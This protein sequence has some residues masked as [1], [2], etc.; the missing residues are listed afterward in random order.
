MA[1]QTA[2]WQGGTAFASVGSSTPHRLTLLD[3][4]TGERLAPA[5]LCDAD[6][7]TF[8]LVAGPASLIG[9]G[10]RD[11][12]EPLDGTRHAHPE[13]SSSGVGLLTTVTGSPEPRIV[14]AHPY[15]GVKVWDAAA[16]RCL[17]ELPLPELR[18]PDCLCAGLLS[19]TAG[20]VDTAHLVDA[21]T[22]IAVSEDGQVSV[23]EAE[24]GRPV[25]RWSASGTRVT[26]MIWARSAIGG[27]DALLTTDTEARLCAWDPRTGEPLGQARSLP[28]RPLHLSATVLEAE[29]ARLPLVA[30]AYGDGVYLLC[31]DPNTEAESD[32]DVD[33]GTGADADTGRA[34]LDLRP[35]AWTRTAH[36][37]PNGLLVLGTSA[38]PLALR[39]DTARL[40]AGPGERTELDLTGIP[41]PASTSD[42]GGGTG[43]D[44]AELPSHS[45]LVDL[46]GADQVLVLDDGPANADL[47]AQAREVLC[48]IG[49][50]RCPVPGLSLDKDLA[51]DGPA[52]LDEVGVG[53]EDPD[54]PDALHVPEGMDD[55]H[56]LGT[57]HDDDLVLS[58]A[59]AVEIV[60]AESDYEE[61]T[62]L[63][64]SLAAFV[65]FA[66]EFALVALQQEPEYDAEAQEARVER[67]ER[68]LRT[69]DGAAFA[70]DS[71][72]HWAD[73]LSELESGM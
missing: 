31:T 3:A 70:P 51:T 42:D 33:A 19:R 13:E 62:L 38:G 37:S 36:L 59:G 44:A 57:W 47:A 7:D 30:C 55:Y 29:D 24:I 43:R 10:P 14:T 56:W 25:A 39:L 9:V 72:E 4:A 50:P 1:A 21:T 49:L 69:V 40:A 53:P 64:S 2:A 5:M 60:G 52:P 28:G 23:H 63:N 45:D 34:L 67:L 68:R 15:D 17:V 65:T 12:V 35:N 8:A 26:H 73:A 61:A 32:V 6:E 11:V 20:L 71:A 27:R 58:P 54:D 18:S 46:W 48:G 22:Y 66:R 16:R 41:A